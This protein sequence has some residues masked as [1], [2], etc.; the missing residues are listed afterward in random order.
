MHI[1]NLSNPVLAAYASAQIQDTRATFW[2]LGVLMVMA[3]ALWVMFV[4]AT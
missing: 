1:L 2:T 4:A 3:M